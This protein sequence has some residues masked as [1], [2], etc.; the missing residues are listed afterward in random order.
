VAD[1]T[2]LLLAFDDVQLLDVAGP[3]EVFHT[4]SRLGAPYRV[5]LA[6]PDARPVR[7]SSGVELDGTAGLRVPP[8]GI[9]TL[10]VAGGF[11]TRSSGRDERLV[12]FVRRAAARSRRVASVCTGAYL[13][14]EAGVLDGRRATT[15]WASADHLAAR[16]EAVDVDPEPIFVRDGH[17]WTSAGVTAGMDLALALMA[18]DEGQRLAAE[19]ARYLV[20]FVRRPGGQ[21]QFSAQLAAQAAE[22]EPVREIQAW[23]ADHLAEDLSV[24]ALAARALM[25][26]RNFARVFRREVGMTPAAYVERLR[27]EA[28]RRALEDGTQPVETIA[29]GCGFGTA[30]T[31]HRAFRRR[32]GTSPGQYRRLHAI[33]D[34]A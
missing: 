4:A 20:L 17:V 29:R 10:I 15:H 22:H 16:H 6:T 32:L 18:E 26:T 2:I 13:L 9:D 31:M 21:S 8:G 34:A 12:P 5:E 33:H 19:V 27:V 7:T 23:C 28:A 3:L 30:E 24:P 11:G 14:A 1:R 25:S